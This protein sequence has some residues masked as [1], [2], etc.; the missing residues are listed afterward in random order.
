MMQYIIKKWL[1]PSLGR[2]WASRC[3]RRTR[4]TI[5]TLSTRAPLRNL[6]R[7]RCSGPGARNG[8]SEKER[9]REKRKTERKRDRYCHQHG[10]HASTP[11]AATGVPRS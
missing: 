1:G 8:E 10:R 4:Q 6:F 7:R 2:W 9:E 3:G 11:A 5:R